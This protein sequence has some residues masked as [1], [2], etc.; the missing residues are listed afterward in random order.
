LSEPFRFQ[1]GLIHWRGPAP[2]YFAT[3][4]ADVGAEIAARAGQV[5]Y[6]WGVI[7]VQAEIAGVAFST[8]LFPKDGAYLLPLKVKV[9]ARLGEVLDTPFAVCMTLGRGSVPRG[10]GM[11]GLGPSD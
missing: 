1:S 11:E 6:G 8:S 10:R 7:P 3:I 2:F 4:P 5:S 9:R